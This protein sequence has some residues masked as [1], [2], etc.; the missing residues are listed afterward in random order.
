MFSYK[1]KKKLNVLF[2]VIG[3]VEN[4]TLQNCKTNHVCKNFK[5]KTGTGTGTG[6]GTK[7]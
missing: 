7:T 3:K 2:I 4:S 5:F 6:T 1:I